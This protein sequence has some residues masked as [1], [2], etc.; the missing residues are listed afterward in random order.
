MQ[1]E[2]DFIKIGDEQHVSGQV[3]L[4]ADQFANQKMN[5]NDAEENDQNRNPV[6]DP[7]FGD[8][9]IGSYNDDLKQAEPP[10]IPALRTDDTRTTPMSNAGPM[11]NING[12]T[13]AQRNMR[14]RIY[15]ANDVLNGVGGNE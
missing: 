11:L 7:E 1:D 10:N 3:D 8:I 9:Q 15:A 2:R 12:N 6:Q 14:G 5:Y 13:M 4:L